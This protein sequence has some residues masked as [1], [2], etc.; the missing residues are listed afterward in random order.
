MVTSLPITHTYAQPGQYTVSVTVVGKEGG[1]PTTATY[2][3]WVIPRPLITYTAPV[4]ATADQPTA[5]T[6]PIALVVEPN[7]G[8]GPAGSPTISWGDGTSSVGSLSGGGGLFALTG[9]HTYAVDVGTYAVSAV[10]AFNP[11]QSVPILTNALVA[12]DRALKTLPRA[13]VQD[14]A[15]GQFKWSVTVADA[16]G[17]SVQAQFSF[18]PSVKN[19]A[20]TITFMQ[21][22]LETTLDGKPNYPGRAAVREFYPQFSTDKQKANMIDI[23]KGKTEPYFSIEWKEGMWVAEWGKGDAIGVG[24][25]KAI[26]TT[27]DKP[28]DPRARTRKGVSR[29]LLEMAAFCVDTQQILGVVT[30]GYQVPDNAKDPTVILNSFVADYSLNASATYKGLIEKA[31]GDQTN[32]PKGLGGVMAHAKLD[33]SPKVSKPITDKMDLKGTSALP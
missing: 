22:V 21:C 23:I 6:A 13:G 18:E 2:T 20:T 33:G 25:P 17:K 4:Y 29:S 31:N 24:N 28:N 5:G 19:P 9:I 7:P 1:S 11:A 8:G 27:S 30:W 26:A 10:L 15:M 16:F 14:G 3:A 12:I 32:D